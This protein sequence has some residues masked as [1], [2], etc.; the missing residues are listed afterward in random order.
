MLFSFASMLAAA[1]VTGPFY[2][3]S[4]IEFD[5]AVALRVCRQ[6]L[7]KVKVDFRGDGA[8]IAVQQLRCPMEGAESAP[9]AHILVA[10]DW[11]QPLL[12]ASD[13]SIVG[14]TVVPAGRGE[15]LLVQQLIGQYSVF[16]VLAL[17]RGAISFLQP[18]D[19]S[20][21]LRGKEEL[22][23]DDVQVRGGLV[24][25]TLVVFDRPREEYGSQ[26][27]TELIAKIRPDPAR[28]VLRLVSLR[29]TG[30]PPER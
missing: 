12:F 13:D 30:R 25:A 24:V 9:L 8:P 10:K 6:I 27:V 4:P 1:A 17:H 7:R 19:L 5:A 16:G 26:V 20:R 3:E 2:I 15:A 28:G 22:G 11:P 14:L 29:R 18:P 21:G 23:G